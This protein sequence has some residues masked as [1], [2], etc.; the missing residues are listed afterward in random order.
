MKAKNMLALLLAL[1]MLFALAA[2]GESKSA[3]ED[4]IKDGVESAVQEAKPAVEPAK[5]AAEPEKKPAEAPAAEAAE[6]PAEE[7]A[8]EP[9]PEPE[10]EPTLVGT[11]ICEKDLREIMAQELGEEDPDTA[12]TLMEYEKDIPFVMTLEL[13]EDATCTLTPDM[14]KTKDSMLDFFRYYLTKM[15]EASGVTMGDE[16]ID[17]MAQQ[18]M[19]SFATDMSPVEGTYDETSSLLTLEGNDPIAFVFNGDSLDIAV[20]GFGD[21]H[22]VRLG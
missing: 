11:W 1:V 21:L 10:A 19:D 2:C 17:A 22:F 15:F 4:T 8:E 20:E 7:P 13:R 16:F 3:A 12:K 18:S 5:E 9:A 6:A 14:S